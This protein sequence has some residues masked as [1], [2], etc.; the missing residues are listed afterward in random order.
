MQFASFF[1]PYL[2]RAAVDV[3][4][5]G[6][7]GD[8]RC[9]AP[10]AVVPRVS[11]DVL[12]VQDDWDLLV[13]PSLAKDLLARL[14]ARGHSLWYLHAAPPD[15]DAIPLD[16][17]PFDDTSRGRSTQ[18]WARTHRRLLGASAAASAVALALRTRR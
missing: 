17:G 18:L 9:F 16:H 2:R 6:A 12:V 8:Y 1:D 14:G 7:S 15:V 3:G 13:D 5:I 10:D 4:G 11:G